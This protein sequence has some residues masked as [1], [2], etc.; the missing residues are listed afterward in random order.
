[1]VH[2]IL[3]YG[4]TG[5]SGGL[6]AEE[7]AERGMAGGSRCRMVLAGRDS[8]TVSELG[9]QYRMDAR[10]FGLENPDTVIRELQDVDVVINAAGPF[11]LTADHLA[12]GALAAGCHYVDINGEAEVYLSLDDLGRHAVRRGLAMVSGAGHTAAASD[13]LLSA[14]LKVL[15]A[16]YPGEQELG[17]VRIA[18]SR[19]TTLSRGSL[20]TLWRALREQVRVVRLDKG[21]TDAHE[22]RRHILWH[23]PV[24]R[25]ERTFDFFHDKRPGLSEKTKQTC[26]DFQVAS[27]AN[28]VDTLTARLTLERE[29]YRAHRLESYVEVGGVGR[30][31]FQL[32]PMLTPLAALPWTRDFTRMQLA[33]LPVGPD[34]NER[35]AQSHVVVLEVED[36]FHQKILDWAW[37][38]PNPYDFT[39]RIVLDV[40]CKVAEGGLSGWLTPSEVLGLNRQDL[41]ADTGSLRGCR[42][43]SRK[44][45]FEDKK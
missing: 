41:T 34:K 21:S 37:L 9:R 43:T 40:A 27:A 44:P 19:L 39:S 29:R 18:M 1:M 22:S 14:A 20:E 2:T 23:E 12:R 6:I 35:S 30:M 26:H 8:R 7:A 24:G 25:L 31:V 5:Y 45:V 17:A 4:A 10:A 13:L 32:A 11:A 33:T 42:L 15:T 28:V 36:C 16:G 38:T 3:L